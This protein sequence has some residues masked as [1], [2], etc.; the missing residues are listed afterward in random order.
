MLTKEKGCDNMS[1]LS[2]W[3]MP[4]TQHISHWAYKN[5]DK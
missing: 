3:Q 5:L 4:K 2:Q 1:K